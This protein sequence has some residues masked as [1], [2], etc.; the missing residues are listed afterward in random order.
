[1]LGTHTVVVDL[2]E[3]ELAKLFTNAWRYLQFAIANQFYTI[4]T[5][6]N[7]DF[8]RV[9]RAMTDGYERA[10]DFPKP[11]FSAGPCLLKDTMQLVSFCQGNFQL[12]QD[13]I[14]INEGL[15]NIIVGVLRRK[16]R[17]TLNG[18]RVGILGMAFKADIDDIRESLSYKLSKL[19]KFEGAEVL[20]SDEY[21]KDPAF[22]TKE[23]LLDS[24]P[25]IVI[26]VPHSAYHGLKPPKKV[27]VI[28]LWNVVGDASAKERR[29]S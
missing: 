17:G 1:M 23:E 4:A 28:D 8:G 19:L 6:H 29:T 11:G 26:G 7:V 16:H 12:G 14:R 5:E 24:C 22:V 9:Y 21:V 15:P 25:L 3:A 10:R 13:A 27:S 20:C 2:L 18:A